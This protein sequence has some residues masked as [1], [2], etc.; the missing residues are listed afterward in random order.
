MG[1]VDREV[2]RV[3]FCTPCSVGFAVVLVLIWGGCAVRVVLSFRMV[4]F[5][6]DGLLGIVGVDSGELFSLGFGVFYG[7]LWVVARVNFGL[8][9]CC[10]VDII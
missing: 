8:L 7:V 1:P 10:R 3:G 4:V 9:R 5:G 2:C 6:R